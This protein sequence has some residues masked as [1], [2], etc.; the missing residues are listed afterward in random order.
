M[1]DFPRPFAGDGLR[2]QETTTI[3]VGGGRKPTIF[4]STGVSPGGDY[5]TLAILESAQNKKAG[6]PRSTSSNNWSRRPDLN[7]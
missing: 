2:G 3:T 6:K 4:I 7:R 1:V 5:L